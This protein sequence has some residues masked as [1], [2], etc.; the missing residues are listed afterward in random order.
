MRAEL[1]LVY[2]GKKIF[3]NFTLDRGTNGFVSLVKS[4]FLPDKLTNHILHTAY[5]C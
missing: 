3:E 5:L 1:I 2:I 4:G